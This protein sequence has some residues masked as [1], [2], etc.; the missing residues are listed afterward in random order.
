MVEESEDEVFSGRNVP[1]L[2]EPVEI[3]ED[4]AQ[5]YY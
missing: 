4:D 2:Y 1:V 3:G 5:G